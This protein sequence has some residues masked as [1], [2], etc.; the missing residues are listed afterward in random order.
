M[1]KKRKADSGVDSDAAKPPVATSGLI[2]KSNAAKREA[3]K[4]AKEAKAM[5]EAAAAQGSSVVGAAVADAKKK[6]SELKALR[7]AGSLDEASFNDQKSDLL[8][9]MEASRKAA[10]KA[11]AKVVAGEEGA[12]GGEGTGGGGGGGKEAMGDGKV[13]GNGGAKA[14][15]K[16][17]AKETEAGAVLKALEGFH[18]AEA[19]VARK[20]TPKKKGAAEAGVAGDGNDKKNKA[21][22]AA[23][24]PKAN[25][26]KGSVASQVVP[27]SLSLHVSQLP[28]DATKQRLSAHFEAHGCSVSENKGTR[29][30][31]DAK[32]DPTGVA[33]V[34]VKDEKSWRLGLKLHRSR[35]GGR[36][37]NVRPTR[38]V[39]ELAEIVKKRNE[40]MATAGLGWKTA[41]KNADAGAAKRPRTDGA[42]FEKRGD[43]GGKGA[44]KGGKGMGKGAGKGG[45]GGKGKGMRKGGSDGEK[46]I[47][48]PDL[49]ALASREKWSKSK[50]T[51]ERK[52]KQ[53][54][55][56]Q[57]A[58]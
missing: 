1:S 24:S 33:F 49:E 15:A 2:D 34:D 31:F 42:G 46:A 43:A 41:D 27:S 52:K 35:F 36:L 53:A 12:G 3:K 9:A 5:A 32:G 6:L 13:E 51:R 22:P 25:A 48:R 19:K 10:A 28:F 57:A 29:F 20:D 37:I 17:K 40:A 26:E 54:A 56:A 16:A 8:R 14:E 39:A 55:A 30:C 44:G 18:K 47:A 38:T 58:A 21:S 45:K 50:A 7:K 11:A 23:K 4:K